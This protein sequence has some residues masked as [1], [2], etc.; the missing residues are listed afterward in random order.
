MIPEKEGSKV[1]DK[2]LPSQKPTRK[3]RS[4]KMEGQGSTDVC[5]RLWRQMVAGL[6]Q[7]MTMTLWFLDSVILCCALGHQS[8]DG[9]SCGKTLSQHS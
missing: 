1:Q 2:S 9:I 7:P 6:F 3:E 5:D 8:W 4:I